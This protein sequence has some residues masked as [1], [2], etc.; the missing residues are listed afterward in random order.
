MGLLCFTW[1]TTM[2]DWWRR[3]LWSVLK[4][5]VGMELRGREGGSSG[6]WV[7]CLAPF[8]FLPGPV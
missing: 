1:N 5:V 6:G 8:L 7:G 4:I 2:Q 3:S